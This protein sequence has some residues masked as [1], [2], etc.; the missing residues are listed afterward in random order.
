MPQYYCKSWT[1]GKCRGMGPT[2]ISELGEEA[3]LSGWPLSG[4]GQVSL[5]LLFTGGS[6]RAEACE[7]GLT[8]SI[9]LSLLDLI[10]LTFA[11]HCAL[12]DV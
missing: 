8:A 10:I 2:A 3:Q 11:G 5:S 9:K 6:E 4:K 7:R 12:A 1:E